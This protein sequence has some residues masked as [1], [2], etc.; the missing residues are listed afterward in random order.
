MLLTSTRCS[1]A[2]VIFDHSLAPAELKLMSTV[3][4]PVVAS[5]PTVAVLTSLAWRLLS[6][7]QWYPDR[8][9]R[10]V[11]ELRGVVVALLVRDER[12][13][14]EEFVAA[15]GDRGREIQP[16]RRA[17]GVHRLLEADAG[18]LHQDLV[19]PLR[20]NARLGHAE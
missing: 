7:F 2:V 3:I 15:P 20:L 19:V 18:K 5:V 6:I 4:A 14:S 9:M 16:R 1:A 11:G 8:V 13:S 17:D 10:G 12:S